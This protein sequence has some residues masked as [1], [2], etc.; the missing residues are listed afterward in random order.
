MFRD[1]SF[2]PYGTG[3]KRSDQEKQTDIRGALLSVATIAGF[4][5]ARKKLA[6]TRGVSR[7]ILR[8][9]LANESRY[10]KYLV[11]ASRAT[12][13]K[14]VKS[15][16]EGMLDKFEDAG[17]GMM[18]T[19]RDLVR[20]LPSGEEQYNIAIGFLEKH[21]KQPKDIF[22]T[23][24]SLGIREPGLIERLFGGPTVVPFAPGTTLG[25][26]GKAG[27]P[28]KVG[29]HGALLIGSELHF[30]MDPARARELKTFS[31]F[32]VTGVQAA[33]TH[34]WGAN[35]ERAKRGI[36]MPL[37][38]RTTEE[39]VRKVEIASSSVI[40]AERKQFIIEKYFGKFFP[41]R[42]DL[43]GKTYE[44]LVEL[45]QKEHT[46]ANISGSD[47]WRNPV[48][49][50]SERIPT[51]EQFMG[52]QVSAYEDVSR[53]SLTFRRLLLENA[54]KTRRTISAEAAQSKFYQGKFKFFQQAR[55]FG[56][57][58]E[59]A[60]YGAGVVQGKM[61]RPFQESAARY[62]KHPDT[63]DLLNV[64]PRRYNRIGKTLG[65][66][67]G[68]MEGDWY[69]TT[70]SDTLRRNLSLLSGGTLHKVFEK[71]T[72]FGITGRGNIATDFIRDAIG[73]KP[74]S[75]S[76]LWA[77]NVGKTARIMGLGFGAWYS[78]QFI[79]YLSRQVTGWGPTDVAAAT[80]TKG[81]EFQQHVLQALGIVNASKT[82]ENAFPG[83]I[84]SPASRA[85]RLMS[86]LIFA[87]FFG[88]K[89]GPK[90]Y[91]AGLGLG[92]ATAMVTWGDI[93]QSPEELHRIYSGEQ[94][95]PVRKGRYWLLGKTPF[96]G[97]KIAYWRQ[98]WYPLL[99]SR[100]KYRGG[101]WDSET[102]S[103]AQGSPLS[104]ILAPILTGKMWDPY[105]WEKKHYR[106]RPY[107][108]TGELFEPTMPFAWLGNLTLGRALKP[109][110]IMHPE[111]LGSSQTTSEGTERGVP[112]YA[113]EALG[114]SSLPGAGINKADS[115]FSLRYQ[116]GMGAYTQTEQM[117]LLGFG[118][119]TLYQ[120]LT[121]QQDF[122]GSQSV[123]QTSRRATGYERSYW[124]REFG[125]PGALADEGLTEYFRRFLP[126]RRT[127]V[128][129]YNPI[130][131]E[132]PDWMPGADYF[133]N[134]RTGDPYI[135]V[136]FGEA[137]LPGAGYATL[138]E[139]HSGIPGTYDAVDRFMILA[140][141]APY[142]NAYNEY[143]ILAKG[144]V[145]DDDYWSRKV[146]R[147]LEQRNALNQEYEFLSTGTEGVPLPL[148]P[149]SSIYRH[150]LAAVTNA[151][152]PLDV[153][154]HTAFVG[155][156]VP[157]HTNKWLPYKTAESTYKDFR[158]YGS[159]YAMWDKPMQG[160]VLPYMN[161]IRGMFDPN[162]V[163]SSVKRRREIQ[164]YFDKLKYIK[165]SNLA[166]LARHQSNS[167]LSM[168]LSRVANN[169][170]A[171]G[172]Y[173][174]GSAM[175][176]IP[177]EEKP[178]FE[179]FS[180]AKGEERTRILNVVPSYMRNYYMTAWN[181]EDGEESYNVDYQNARDLT[182]YFKTHNLPP[183]NWLG[184]HPDVSLDQVKLRVVKNEAFDIHKFNLWESNE[185]LLA[186]QPFTPSINNINA[187][188]HDLTMLQ[189]IMRTNMEKFGMTEN[190]IN[191]SRTPASED[192]FK[193]RINFK[194]DR[195]EDHDRAMKSALLMR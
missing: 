2:D 41:G 127:N 111:Y 30:L 190:R 93:T 159:E 109:P 62:F 71:V 84:N 63:G 172:Q 145:K 11:S 8:A 32:K 107:P 95:I 106:D 105:Y 86:P 187:P 6:L 20:P 170:M 176:S 102:E 89:Y 92:I 192:S 5:A 25:V 149:L 124:E 125:D 70:P 1:Y 110:R 75:W 121:G 120:K 83:T 153:L 27:V 175:R 177:K 87:R 91:L 17:I 165:Y 19:I 135:K 143:K 24:K 189:N 138:H 64:T 35:L 139:F 134:F 168:R 137:R 144:M 157:T 79:N 158:L 188:S 12:A 174:A 56:V 18:D 151:P 129:E 179:A 103:W 22:P 81:R 73:A 82:I 162:F 13:S 58:E 38:P 39:Y 34:A 53:K 117:G 185:R 116:L 115:P 114:F 23:W 193:M 108:L 37:N 182:G 9:G 3:G 50:T 46:L 180:N 68:G 183:S 40:K 132:M 49:G 65:S 167:D 123:M 173:N 126:H 78:Y 47:W 166:Q 16:R 45:A 69:L 59:F 77:R 130:P 186:R 10:E 55:K 119:N 80:Y 100:Y 148:K 31:Q 48:A 74:G 51:F 15:V 178:F 97:G 101:L 67:W 194:R 169:T 52:K 163:P 88:R 72:G 195:R 33:S 66:N 140:D 112:G 156:A 85:V 4:I 122:M 161:K 141:V 98:H 146:K 171:A 191:I 28:P 36:I 43:R 113:G 57:S 14:N 54:A 76:D 133:T 184:W 61:E 26:I 131:N 60:S 136:P 142:S 118:I 94:E 21:L 150:A 147:A 7:D 29:K 104:P 96:F 128:D 42:G 99:R 181:D 154:P 90:G 152:N 44:E 160:F 155:G 164:E